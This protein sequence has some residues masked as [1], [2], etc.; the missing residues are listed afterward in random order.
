M[1]AVL[2]VGSNLRRPAG[3]PALAVEVLQP[4]AVSPVYETAPVGGVEQDDYLNAVLLCA[5]DAA[6]AWER[7]QEAEQRAGAS[8]ASGGGRAPSTSTSSAPRARAAGLELP[9]PRAAERA[10]VLVLV[11]GRGPLRRA[12]GARP[13]SDPRGTVDVSSVRR[14]DDLVSCHDPHPSADPARAGPVRLRTCSPTCGALGVRVT[15]RPAALRAG[16]HRAARARRGGMAKV[17]RDRLAHRLDERGRPKGRPL[18]P[19]AGRPGAVLAKASSAG[20]AV[21]LGIYGGLLAWTLPRRARWPRASRTPPSPPSPPWRA[22][23]WSSRRWCS[24]A[25]AAGRS[26]PGLPRVHRMSD[27]LDDLQHRRAAPAGVRQGGGRQGRRLLLGRREAHARLAGHRRRGRL[28]RCHHGSIT[29]LV[30]LVREL[31]GKEPLGD[32]EP[33]LRARFLTTSSTES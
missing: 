30:H 32:D 27:T 9:H 3:A 23:A 26:E 31:T 7:A 11:G 22:S 1:T 28:L 21:L 13:I 24:S 18:H 4:H 2:S 20:G 6:Q 15:A 19:D 8:G 16:Q 25:P 14:R 17:V 29:E 12:A 5:L 33:L 10:F